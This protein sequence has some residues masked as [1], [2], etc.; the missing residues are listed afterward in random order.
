MSKRA[1]ALL[2]DD[3]LECIEKINSYLEGLT[4]EQFIDDNKTT[5]A[6]GSVK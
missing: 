6:V 4:F 3:M 5:D 2:I 1:P